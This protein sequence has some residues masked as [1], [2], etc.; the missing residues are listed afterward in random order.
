MGSSQALASIRS[1]TGRDTGATHMISA[2][3]LRT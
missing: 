2:D 3:V 1:P